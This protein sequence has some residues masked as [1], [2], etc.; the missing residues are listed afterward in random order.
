MKSIIIFG[1]GPSLLKCTRDIVD[2]YDDI[3]LCNYPVL[4]EFFYN[5]IENRTINYHFANCGTF[6]ERYNDN[7][8]NLLQ[9]QGIYN[10]NKTDAYIDFISNKDLFKDNLYQPM[11]DY[12][13]NNFD[14]DPATGTMAIQYILN[15]NK[16]D[17]ICLVGFD[18]FQKGSPWYY[19]NPDLYNPKLTYLLGNQITEKGIYNQVSAHS[20]EKTLQYYLNIIE[21]NKNIDYTF[22]TN[23]LLPNIDNLKVI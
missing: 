19:Y 7:I 18:N 4:N 23:L 10:T 14:L 22:V 20:P 9:I 5:L 12:F 3:A 13:F 1:K 16:Y 6:D 8:N 15:L 21:K 2:S 11:R 17:K